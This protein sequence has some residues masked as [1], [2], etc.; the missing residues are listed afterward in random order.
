MAKGKTFVDKLKKGAQE[1]KTSEYVKLVR[2][3]R[4]DN[5]AWKFRTKIVEVTDSNRN[6]IY[7]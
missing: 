3:Y 4:G 7:K 1:K 6:E 2:A 5:G